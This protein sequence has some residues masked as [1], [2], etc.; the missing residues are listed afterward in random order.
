[1]LSIA[2]DPAGNEFMLDLNDGDNGAVYYAFHDQE[3]ADGSNKIRLYNSF[4]DFIG[5]LRQD[6]EPPAGGSLR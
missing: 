2:T 6:D 4:T 3:L 1:M 5:Q